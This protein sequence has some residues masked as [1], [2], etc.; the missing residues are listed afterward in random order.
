MAQQK[1]FKDRRQAGELLAQKLVH[2]SGRANTIVLALPRGGVPVGF[3]VA[4]A[5]GIPLDILL[6]RKLGV[7]GR[8]EYAMGAIASGGLRM[9][10]D[11][12]VNML[13]IPDAAIKEATRR[14]TRELER[15]E[16]LYRA[17]RPA[18]SLQGRTVILIDDGLATGSTMLVAVRAVRRENPAHIIVAVPTASNEACSKIAAEADDVVCLSIPSPFYAVGAWYEDFGQTSDAEVQDLLA[19]AQARFAPRASAYRDKQSHDCPEGAT[20]R[21]LE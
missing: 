7:P 15:R 14:E 3:A 2:Y 21:R 5:L 4:E 9:L 12:V 13:G 18:P 16:K 6:V 19:Q 11:I 8:E 10:Q 20:G 17:G 1:R